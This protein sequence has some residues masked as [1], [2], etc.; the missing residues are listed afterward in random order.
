M[1]LYGATI[2]LSAFLL[3]EVQPIIGRMI[4][5]W[6]GG[7]AAVWT[8]ALLFFQLTLLAGYVYSYCSI[9]YLTPK[10]QAAAHVTLLAASLL[11]LPI[12]PSPAWK[13]AGEGDPALRIIVL[14][15]DSVGLPYFMLST[16][17]PLLQAWFAATHP[18]TI[19]YRLF[20]LSNAGSMLAL[21]SYPV[22]VE[23]FLPGRIQGNAWSAAYAGFAVLGAVVAVA[24]A[25]HRKRVP[26][27]SPAGAAPETRPSR[28]ARWLW[29][30][31]PACASALLIA[32]TNH[33][34]QNVAPMPFL[35][36][37]TLALY[38]LS[39]IL[40]FESDRNYKR[41]V[42]IPLLAI[43][44][45]G[46]SF[47]IY[48]RRGNIRI[49]W[50]VP[51]FAAALFICCMVSHGELARL[52][53]HHRHL[54]GFYVTLAAGGAAGSLFVAVLA[55]RIF[56]SHLDL[57]A[58]MIFCAAL[59]AVVL[60]K[61]LPRLTIR[62]AAAGF[63]VALGAQV[64]YS[65]IADQKRFIASVRN[66]YGVLSVREQPEDEEHSGSRQLVN[67]TILHGAQ[68]TDPEMKGEATSYYG[69]ASGVGRAIELV[70]RSPRVRVGVVGL[71]A[72]VIASY[73]RRGDVFR[74]YE[75]N[76][77]DII[78]A[79]RY[80]TFLK[81]CPGDCQ[82]LT[83]DARLTLERQRPQQF[84]LLAVDA[85]SSDAIPVHLLTREAFAVYFRHLKPD[86]IL[87]VHV[88]N[89]YLD[90]APIVA[91]DA[92]E[93][94]QPAFEITDKP[95]DDYLS[96]STW[97]LVVREARLL[98]LPSFQGA[99]VIR[100]AA[101]KTLRLWTDDFSSLYQIVKW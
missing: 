5:P 75:L 45:A 27:E 24:A 85:F 17:G 9:R 59:A 78:V 22:A 84:D 29:I 91:R 65:H 67:G 50:T 26:V 54:T 21:I 13:P 82:V 49:A 14:L 47:G 19:P 69:R 61:Q 53:P 86:G 96:D 66:F 58:S 38:L 90:L 68:L 63:V 16:T 10:M 88:S 95:D 99:S 36:V 55:P 76:P 4:L 6:F 100:R 25:R 72:G 93:F 15:A 51:L 43:A 60:W 74:F 34:S 87:A 57:P 92:E 94:R 20:A 48:F 39:F 98:A 3:F 42:F 77:L 11:L 37:L 8:T 46:M 80:F 89:R 40:C 64:A 32:V 33:L 62:I 2:V 7:L 18:G 81:D 41:A 44:L 30:A 83:G 31:L 52:K 23:P 70:Q 73:C 35:W 79:N 71:G 97:M 12:I 28:G 56:R 1:L 101:P